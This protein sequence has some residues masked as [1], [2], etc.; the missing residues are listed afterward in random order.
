MEDEMGRHTACMGEI[1]NAYKMSVGRLEGKRSLGRPKHRQK[2]PLIQNNHLK[3]FT[4]M[5]N[6]VCICAHTC[7]CA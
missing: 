2:D 1:R 4:L 5:I 6:S 3:Y 7:V